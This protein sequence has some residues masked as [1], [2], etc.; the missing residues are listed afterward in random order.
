MGDSASWGSRSIHCTANENTKIGKVGSCE[1]TDQE[2]SQCGMAEDMISAISH[3][4]S[5][6]A[7]RISNM[8]HLQ[9]FLNHSSV[10]DIHFLS[11][12]GIAPW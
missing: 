12:G 6:R 8:V 3:E 2:I 4:T 10:R 7:T 1:S 9:A 11:T 5:D